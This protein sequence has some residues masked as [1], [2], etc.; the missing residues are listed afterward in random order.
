MCSVLQFP[1]NDCRGRRRKYMLLEWH[2]GHRTWIGSGSDLSDIVVA[3]SGIWDDALKPR[4]TVLLAKS[5]LLKIHRQ[6]MIFNKTYHAACD[7]F[8]KMF[9][10]SSANNPNVCGHDDY[11][12]Q[13]RV[14]VMNWKTQC[15]TYKLIAS[16]A[17]II[18]SEASSKM[19]YN[20]LNFLIII[21][22]NDKSVCTFCWNLQRR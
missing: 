9:E 19:K 16:C 22:M 5:Y 18:P 21:M 17:N 14:L 20:H 13:K 3:H 15:D 12:S 10:P 11:L 2:S 1:F 4:Q 7:I 6:K 8:V